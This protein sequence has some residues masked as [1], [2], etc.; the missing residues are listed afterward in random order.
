MI[1]YLLPLVFSL[2]FVSCKIFQNPQIASV[3]TDDIPEK[4]T[5]TK[6]SNKS[7]DKWLSDF[8]DKNLFSLVDEAVKNNWNFQ[9]SAARLEEAY[10]VAKIA[11]ADRLPTLNLEGNAS[12]SRSGSNISRQHSNEYGLFARFSW[13]LDIW[14]KL[15]DR[16]E[17]AEADLNSQAFTYHAARLS[18]A[19]SVCR[20]WFNAVEAKLQLLLAEET[21]K[22]FLNTYEIIDE[23]FKRGIS[24][25]LD[26]RLAKVDLANA[27][28]NTQ[29]RKANYD[30]AVRSLEV[31]LGRYPKG[32]LAVEN[33]L[34][35]IL[36]NIPLG[37]PAEMLNRRPDIQAAL[38]ALQA[39]SF[40]TSEKKKE[41]LPGISLTS[42]L[43]NRAESVEDIF[44]AEKI[45]WSLVGSVSQPIFQGGRIRA[46]IEQAKAREKIE[47][48]S[49]IQIFYEACLEVE[50]ASN[51]E[52]FL[53]E[54]EKQIGISVDESQKAFELAK[55]RYSKGLSDII[56]LLVSQRSEFTN[57][58]RLLDVKLQRIL[59]RLNLY[60]A[61]G[62]DYDEKTSKTEEKN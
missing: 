1:K 20:F 33:T 39:A 37:I 9:A 40:R 36:E 41:L 17:A 45:L 15:K 8:K 19:A 56:T 57:R 51:A 35:E 31:L 11:G 13:E 4:W 53:K 5:F 29:Q 30:A 34:P 42:S 2:T 44:N 10:A 6:N 22:S 58:S 60:L 50:T 28:Q 52:K 25:A 3:K 62:G 59:N 27:R 38:E 7:I 23:R 18:L 46:H 55:D 48:V 14:G 47:F 12:R 49:L 26:L 61:L 32:E 21:E 24:E 43:G 54:K 16:K